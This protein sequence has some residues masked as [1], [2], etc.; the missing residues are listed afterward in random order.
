MPQYSVYRCDVHS[1]NLNQ[2][3]NGP[4][5]PDRFQQ[6]DL[7]GE[8]SDGRKYAIYRFFIYHDGFMC[9]TG[10]SATANGMY[11]QPISLPA[12]FRTDPNAVRIVSITPPGVSISVVL[13]K[14]RRDLIKGMTE[15]RVITDANG[16]E[17]VVFL[18]LIGFLGDTPGLNAVLD[19]GGHSAN[20]FCHRC[21]IQKQT[22]QIFGNQFSADVSW[23]DTSQRRT[24]CKQIAV[25]DMKVPDAMLRALG[26]KVAMSEVQNE[27][28][29]WCDEFYRA[30]GDVPKTNQN[31]S[32]VHCAFDPFAGSFI[33]PNHL[34][35]G[36]FRDCMSYAFRVLPNAE[37]RRF[38]TAQR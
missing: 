26:M 27:L 24:A 7:F 35:S 29:L 6:S 15:G 25:R 13:S 19:V 3:H 4:R 28:Y 14:L 20:S 8:L 34:L 5:G 2:I 11:I 16:V 38:L 33:S 30:R 37:K 21:R 17:R 23:F 1:I 12:R 32:V 10:S 22:D 31:V 36:H 9:A 18:H